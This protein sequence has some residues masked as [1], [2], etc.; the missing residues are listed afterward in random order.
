M[1]VPPA[2][3]V[4]AVGALMVAVGARLLLVTVRVAPALVALPNGLVAMARKPPP[5]S[6]PTTVARVYWLPVAPAMSTPPRCQWKVGAGEPD[7][8]T[9]KLALPPRGT[10]VLCGCWV[11]T[12][13][14]E[15]LM[16]RTAESRRAR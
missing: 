7:A 6:P 8:A 1:T 14:C 4:P 5:S 12:G 10:L 13:A 11:I 16:R 2:K 3:V 9:V 15:W